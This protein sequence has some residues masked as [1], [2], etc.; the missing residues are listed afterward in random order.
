MT[1]TQQHD[2]P[3]ETP[4]TPLG[5][6]WNVPGAIP[7]IDELLGVDLRHQFSLEADQ[8]EE[9]GH[10]GKRN[11]DRQVRRWDRPCDTFSRHHRHQD[12]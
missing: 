5:T 4:N 12:D 1:P 8:H 11:P 7:N 9:R 3:I 10:C 2:V 6:Q